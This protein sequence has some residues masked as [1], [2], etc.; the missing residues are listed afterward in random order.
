MFFTPAFAQMNNFSDDEL[1]NYP[2][3]FDLMQK[4][5]P[6]YFEVKKAYDLYFEKHEK[7]RGTGYKNFERWAWKNRGDFDELGFLNP[8]KL[9]KSYMRENQNG[10]NRGPSGNAGNWI[11]LGPKVY[12][13]NVSG[14]ET[15][16][17]RVNAIAFHPTDPDVFWIGAPSGGLWQSNDGGDSYFSNT[18]QLPS[19]GVSSIIV[20]PVNP[21][22]IFI[23]TGDRDAGNAPGLGV[24]R[25]VDGGANW[26]QQNNGMGDRTVSDMIIHPTNRRTILAATSNGIYKTIN[27]G[28]NWTLKS[29]SSHFKDIEYHPTNPNYAY[30]TA[31]GL[32]YRSTDAGESWVQI[33]SGLIACSRM[34]LGVTPDEPNSVFCLLT[35]GSAIFHGIFKSTDSGLNFTRITPSSHA[36]ILGYNDG[37]D[38]SQANYDLCMLID[39]GDA[40]K[41]LVGSINIHLSTNGGLNFTKKTHWSNQLHADQHVVARNPLNGRIYEGHDGGLHYSD[42]YFTTWTNISGGLRIGQTYRIGQAAYNRKL[43]INGYQDNG[44]SIVKDDIFYTVAGGDGMESAFDYSDENYVYTTYIS[45][46]KRSN[47]RGIGGWN[48]IATEDE[49]GIDE[50]G[51]W[52]TP[53]SLHVTDP[54]T[55]FFGY[56]NI[57]RTNN[58]KSDPPTWT[59]I[60]N[61]L[62]GTNSYN[63]VYTDQSLADPNT[64]YAV[65]ENNT[66][67]RSDNVNDL[68]PGWIDLSGYLPEGNSNIDDIICHPT[69]PEIVYLIQNEK[70]YKSGDKGQTWTN[71][72]G[73]IPTS[74]NLNTLVIDKFGNESLYVGTK[75][76]VYHKNAGLADWIAFDGDLPVVDVREMEIYY[77]GTASRLRAGTYGRG[78][79]ETDLYFVDNQAP[80]ANFAASKTICEVGDDIK[81]E[82]LSAI[83]PTSWTWTITPATYTFINGTNSGSQHPEVEFSA[84]GLY[85]ITLNVTNSYGSNSKTINKYIQ[86]F[87]IVAPNCTPVTQNLGGYGMGI[88]Q[89]QLNTINYYSSDAQG[90][91][92]NPPKGYLNLISTQN[93][94]LLANT[95]YTFTAQIGHNVNSYKQYWKVYIDYNNDGD[96][97]DANELIYSSPSAVA[98]VYSTTFTTLSNPPVV[99]QLIRL[100]IISDYYTLSGP[101][102]N[103]DYGQAEDYGIIFKN[104]PSLS[105]NNITDITY[106]SAESGGNITQQGG[107]AVIA[108]GLVWNIRSGA[109]L[110]NNWGYSE[111]GSGT[112]SFTVTIPALSANTLYYVRA[113]AI[114][115]DGIAYG[116]EEIFTTLDQI[117]E[118]S[119]TTPFQ[120][121]YLTATSGGNITDDKGKTILERGVV[122]NTTGEPSLSSCIGKTTDGTGSGIFVSNITGLNTNTQYYV[123]AYARNS[124][125]IGYGE[126]K[127]FTTLPE[128]INQSSNIIF[129][130][131]STSKI[132]L[133]WTNGTGASRIVKINNVNSFTLP[134]NGTNPSANT[135]YAGGE[136]VIYNGSGNSVTV[137]NLNPATTYYFHVF[138]YNGSGASTVYNIAPGNGNPTSRATYCLPTYANG[139]VQT[140]IKG[141][142]IN[143]INNISGS[144]H[145]TDYTN[146]STALLAGETYDVSV[147]MS[148]NTLRV[149]LWI[150]FNDNSIFET[151]EKLL[152]DLS[153]PG[154]HTTTTQITIPSSVDPGS[155]V[156]RVRA[157]WSSGYDACAVGNWGEAED[158][159]VEIKDFFTWDGSSSN[160]WNTGSNWDVGKVPG[161]GDIVEIE[162][163]ANEPVIQVGQTV[164]VKKVTFLNGSEIEVNGTLNVEE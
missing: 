23:G 129:S 48:I 126:E 108:R 87:S 15:G 32:F 154:N 38:H 73:S 86:V 3:W 5:N 57:W 51:A 30:A 157:A 159:M 120:V 44:T 68:T 27:S 134:V 138:D 113:Y 121:L 82:D 107:S 10:F 60:S 34:V 152:S 35:G 75:T 141:F 67:F 81:L 93:T 31:N 139:D 66:V 118:V 16:T 89:V 110:D 131:V 80:V 11:E 29:V 158:Y 116:N 37:D 58:V 33:T 106:N 88:Y 105:T 117:P 53:Y 128:D 70:I 149:S 83:S 163:V 20:H 21:D 50:E 17:G 100:R 111:N 101:C 59:K 104:L 40:D 103:P 95:Q 155:H 144:S 76:G 148:Y 65:K 63:F 41:I 135:V 125:G 112:G 162:N 153:C 151:S 150:D 160:N 19:L 146:L 143:K 156:L 71:I 45:T 18:D 24:F 133:E 78:L 72:T 132:K 12:P 69:D 77:G 14:Q 47:T 8:A 130:E 1:R 4:E 122:W 142:I 94:I 90:D 109:T 164:N 64:F 55:M 124:Y 25:S 84:S 52:V 91:N 127:T 7:A 92:P 123:K 99:N 39:P 56:K 147:E 102:D 114:N 62:G 36:N 85:T 161:T 74:N 119:T 2:H 43:V 98:G 13:V 42:D 115:S 22:T 136:Q 96:F 54:N 6:N 140:H 79:W 145:Y 28:N 137:T 61:S 49:N 97:E 26:T 46:I 9:F